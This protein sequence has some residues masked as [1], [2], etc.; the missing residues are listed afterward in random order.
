MTES[1]STDESGP[2]SGYPA[3]AGPERSVALNVVLFALTVV[4]VFSAGRAAVVAAGRVPEENAELLD[5]WPFAV[6]FLLIF[7]FHEFGHWILARLHQVPASLPYFIPVPF[8]SWFGTF[9]AVIV[10]PERIRSRNALLDIGAAGPLA[11]MLIAIPTMVIGLKLSVV[12]PQ[13]TEGYIQEGQGL[14][15]LLVKYLVLGPIPDGYDVQLHPTAFAAWGGFLITM[16]NLVPWGQL[17]GG[18]VAYALFGERQNRYARWVHAAL[19][20]L[21]IYNMLQF[22]L[23][24][25]QRGKHVDFAEVFGNSTFWLFWFVLL[26]IM[27]RMHGHHHPPFESGELTPGR[28]RVA[29]VTLGLFVVLFMPTPFA[30]H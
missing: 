12:G 26:L 28:R 11:G 15:Y 5:G 13:L 17:D 2:T 30:L 16:I 25:W 7:V 21:F 22:S 29:W 10:M 24:L 4:S 20:V 1:R 18:H 3:P 14:L 8:L 19:P 9:G 6:P 27:G 23:P